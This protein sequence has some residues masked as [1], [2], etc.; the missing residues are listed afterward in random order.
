MLGSI[1]RTL[2]LT[3]L[4]IA[5]P[6]FYDLA[7]GQAGKQITRFAATF[8]VPENGPGD[9]FHAIWPGLLNQDGLFIL[10]NVV[11]DE[12]GT[13]NTG[14]WEFAPWYGPDGSAGIGYHQYRDHIIS[15]Q[16]GDYVNSTFTLDDTSDSSSAW[17]SSWSISGSTS[18]SDSVQSKLVQSNSRKPFSSAAL[19]LE[20]QSGGVWDFGPIEWTDI[21]VTVDTTD[22]DWC[23]KDAW[24][25]KGYGKTPVNTIASDGVVSQDNDKTICSFDKVIF[26]SA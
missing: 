17:T 2:A 19:F 24:S 11:D 3:H 7:L 21:E 4:A 20:F 13:G 26:D 10:Q 1:I 14:S 23:S 8:R 16:P 18:S 6:V 9:G 5:S 25:S 15:V 22:S 12:Q